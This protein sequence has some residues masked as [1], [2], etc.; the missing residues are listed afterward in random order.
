MSIHLKTGDGFKYLSSLLL[1]TSGGWKMVSQA[2]LKTADGWKS[3]FSSSN[4]SEIDNRVEISQAINFTTKLVTLTGKNYHWTPTPSSLEYAFE[5]FNGSNWVVITGGTILN[6]NVGASNTV[7]YQVTNSSSNIL[8]NVEN[9]YRFNVRS[10]YNSNA[11]SSTSLETSIFTPTNITLSATAPS[12]NSESSMNLSWTT[13]T[14]A[15]SYIVQYRQSGINAAWSTVDTMTGTSTTIYMLSPST[16][17]DF[18][19]LPITGNATYHGYDGNY[20][21]VVTN[22]TTGALICTSLPQI[23]GIIKENNTVTGSTGTWNLNVDSFEYQWLFF[24]QFGVGY[25]GYV[26]ISNAWNST[27]NIPLNY[28]TLYGTKLRLRVKAIKSGYSDVYAYSTPVIVEDFK[29][30]IIQSV[31]VTPSTGVQ[32]QTQFTAN[33]ALSQGD[34]P[35]TY[36]YQWKYHDQGTTWLNATDVNGGTA[37]TFIAPSLFAV[38]SMN[39][40][41]RCYVTVS[42]DAGT[43]PEVY[44]NT[45]TVTAPTCPAGYTYGPWSYTDSN[46]NPTSWTTCSGGTQT[47]AKRRLVT[48]T[49]TD[50]STTQFYQYD[51]DSQS[52]TCTATTVYGDWQYP[53]WSACT[54]CSQSRTPYRSYTST[55]TNCSTSSGTEYGAT[56]TQSCSCTGYCGAWGAWGPYGSWSSCGVYGT[57][58]VKCRTRYR[59]QTCL[60]TCCNEYVN[61][62]SEEEC[63]FC[64]ETKWE[65]INYDVTNSASANYYVCFYVGQCSATYDGGRVPCQ[66]S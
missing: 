42:N 50:C 41:L 27:Y 65:C 47:I 11:N 14:Y 19:V 18:R 7:T 17:Y 57:S 25:E 28:L 44:S 6:P 13:S 63:M 4:V 40:D 36:H 5:W 15:A 22:T 55:A 33:V 66:G 43:S 52:C 38:Y 45:V 29:A 21:N 20:S 61:T 31:T 56:Q 12:T 9:Q 39:G 16:A 1:K 30:P 58:M 62:G 49:Y 48:Y 46:G 64:T 26:P 32:T 35:L 10:F 37:Q 51:S 3:I 54:N 24:D 59:T 8:P 23:S 2:F 34:T 60:D 53:A